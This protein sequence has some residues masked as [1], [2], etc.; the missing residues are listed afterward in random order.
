VRAAG[1][2]PVA[3]RPGGTRSAQTTW[4]EFT[5]AAPDVVFVSSCGFHLDG[6]AQQARM[7]GP[8]FPD[9]E[10]WAIDAD[11][12]AIRPALASSTESRRRQFIW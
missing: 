9:A 4:Q 12:P 3:A 7:V 10:V 2:E 5:D 1:G 6:A 8:M 11:G